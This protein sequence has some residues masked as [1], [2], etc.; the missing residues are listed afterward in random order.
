M[1][2]KKKWLTCTPR[3]FIGTQRFFARD[4]GL[5]SEGFKLAGFDSQAMMAGPAMD[6]DDDR[7][8]RVDPRLFETPEYWKSFEAEGVVLYAWA[9]PR[10]TPIARAIKEAGLKLVINLDSAGLM[11][12]RVDGKIFRDLLFHR[13]RMENTWLIGSLKASFSFIRGMVPR[14]MDLPRLEHM[15][16]AD[17]IGAVSPIARDRVKNYARYY[18]R[19]D[20]ASKVHLI[21][22][23]I[24]QNMTYGG[25]VKKK[26]L[27][28]VGRWTRS[29]WVK[30][31]WLLM[32]LLKIVLN[33]HR[34]YE[35]VVIGAYDDL[36][37]NIISKIDEG[38]RERII[39]AGLIPNAEAA[40]VLQESQISLCTSFSEG[41]HTSSAE[42]LCSGCS[43]VGYQ[44]P[45]LPNLPY[46]AGENSGT[47]A[48]EGTAESIAQAVNIEIKAWQ[49]GERDPKN[50][51][52]TWTS[53]L[54]ARNIP[55]RIFELLE[56]GEI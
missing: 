11:S 12:P 38:V 23:P 19:E 22:H 4:S 30:N 42:A 28:I 13:H 41:F 46:Y 10:Y 47:L 3:R 49:N 25:V 34:D 7:I 40:L 56:Q 17:L 43:V 44:S 32:N 51:S 16:Y 20:I 39:F 53:R 37:K 5:L 6:D 33:K 8:L 48:P 1:L 29:D 15:G 21:L 50:I 27:C 14:W 55:E 24:S 31:P 9:L 35:C 2:S 52:N 36:I 26:Q 54:H 18:G 45:Y